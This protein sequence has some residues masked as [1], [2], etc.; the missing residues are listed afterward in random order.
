[1]TEVINE[2]HFAV[3]RANDD[4]EDMKRLVKEAMQALQVAF[5]Q[6]KVMSTNLWVLWLMAW[7]P[8]SSVGLTVPE[9]ECCP[10]GG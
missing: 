7:A 3:W 9:H 5:S 4:P 2:N 8:S 10:R 1:M 6:L